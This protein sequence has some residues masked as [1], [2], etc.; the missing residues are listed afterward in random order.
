MQV[1]DVTSI[2]VFSSLCL[3]SSFMLVMMVVVDVV[4]RALMYHSV[5]LEPQWM[6]DVLRLCDDLER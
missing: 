5:A 4:R 2:L 6:S 3:M 1:I